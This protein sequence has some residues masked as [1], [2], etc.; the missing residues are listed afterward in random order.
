MAAKKKVK[1][2]KFLAP[3]VVQEIPEGFVMP[4]T[5]QVPNWD[6]EKRQLLQ[7]TIINIKLITKKKVR[8]GEKKTTRLIHVREDGGNLL[9]VWESA[10]LTGLFDEAKKG[11]EVFI[12]FDGHGPKVKGR[13]PM[14]LFATAYRN[15]GKRK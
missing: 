15:P 4:A 2:P 10:A 14:K 1:S 6:F 11:A 7:G 9:Q 8:K 5:A 13:M 12:R 3:K